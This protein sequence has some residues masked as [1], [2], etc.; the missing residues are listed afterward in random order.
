MKESIVKGSTNISKY[1]V[2]H[3]KF[4][5]MRIPHKLAD[6]LDRMCYVRMSHGKVEQGTNKS[7]IHG[8]TR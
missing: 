4:K 6:N 7:S 5:F 8:G 3:R 2:H 1:M